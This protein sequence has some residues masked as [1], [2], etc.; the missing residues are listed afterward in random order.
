[1]KIIIF[2]KEINKI[3]KTRIIPTTKLGFFKPHQIYHVL[4]YKRKS[5]H[6]YIQITRVYTATLESLPKYIKLQPEFKKLQP[7]TKIEILHFKIVYQNEFTKE[8][9]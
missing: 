9:W 8:I 5:S 1:M 3:L 2:P 7:K 4:D 6:T